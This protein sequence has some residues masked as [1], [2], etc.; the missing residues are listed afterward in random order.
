M[1]DNQTCISRRTFFAGGGVGIA[2]L[3]TLGGCNVTFQPSS[4]S[5]N[6]GAAD[7]SIKCKGAFAVEPD[8]ELSDLGVDFS[9]IPDSRTILICVLDIENSSEKNWDDSYATCKLA[10]ETG[11]EYDSQSS[12]DLPLQLQTFVKRCGYTP[13]EDFESI[14]AGA[15]SQRFIVIFSVNK[16]DLKSTATLTFSVGDSAEGSIEIKSKAVNKAVIPDEIF[17]IEKDPDGYQLSKSMP[18]RANLAHALVQ[19]GAD[20]TNAGDSSGGLASLVAA[21]A[22]FSESTKWGVSIMSGS[23]MFDSTL[24]STTKCPKLDFKKLSAADQQT[25]KDAS[26]IHDNLQGM[27]SAFKSNDFSSVNT[28]KNALAVLLNNYTSF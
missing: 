5:D 26:A 7:A 23:S 27:I 2:S 19:A 18:S 24:L 1:R 12:S 14:D 28:Y 22:L 13:L 4:S 25:G 17:N 11:N 3:L 21:D 8:K 15:P 9:D 16:K 6:S 10:Y 20:S